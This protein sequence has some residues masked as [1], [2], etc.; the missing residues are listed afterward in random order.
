MEEVMGNHLYR[1][2]AVVDRHSPSNHKFCPQN[3]FNYEEFT[4][5]E[6]DV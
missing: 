5:E 4:E 3:L 2:E 6:D 1:R